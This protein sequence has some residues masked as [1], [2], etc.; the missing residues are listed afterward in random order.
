MSIQRTSCCC[1]LVTQSCLTLC[2]PMCYTTLGL[3]ASHHLPKFAKFMSISSVPSSHLI[4][5]TPSSP[6]AL[7]FP[8]IRNFSN[9][10]AVCIRWPKY[11]CFSFSISPSNK[12]SGFPL[13][14]TGLISLLSKELSGV[15]S[16][17]TIQRHQFF[18]PSVTTVHDHWE[19]H[20]E[21]IS[22]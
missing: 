11:W 4:L 6:S 9:E 1:C 3:S 22:T 5:L 13:R 14:L 10:P 15:L 17:T 12:Y 7:I 20:R 19:N 18:G 21:H 16:G 2:N 8:C